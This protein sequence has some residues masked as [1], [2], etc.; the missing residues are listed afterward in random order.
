MLAATVH[1]D[2]Y[3]IPEGGVR[4]AASIEWVDGVPLDEVIEASRLFLQGVTD[5]AV[6]SDSAAE[7]GGDGPRSR[8]RLVESG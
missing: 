8:L 1:L 5:E 2:L 3:G 7:G 4:V 6:G